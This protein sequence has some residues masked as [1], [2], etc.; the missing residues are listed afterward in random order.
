MF[1]WMMIN[2]DK[3]IKQN[4][5]YCIVGVSDPRGPSTNQ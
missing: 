2:L 4:I 3:Y 1:K 5:N